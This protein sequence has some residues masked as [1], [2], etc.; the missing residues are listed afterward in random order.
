M[1]LKMTD[2]QEEQEETFG[3]PSRM[4]ISCFYSFLGRQ[5]T[6]RLLTAGL[7]ILLSNIF[8]IPRCKVE[9]NNPCQHYPGNIFEKVG[10]QEIPVAQIQEQ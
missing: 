6:V 5:S 1:I 8:L 7:I 4:S 9:D 2:A 10:F 3:N